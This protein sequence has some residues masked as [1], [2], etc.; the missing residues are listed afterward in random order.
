VRDHGRERPDQVAGRLGRV[1]GGVGI[2]TEDAKVATIRSEEPDRQPPT[3]S[4]RPEVLRPA[5]DL[6][7]RHGQIRDAGSTT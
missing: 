5:V 7:E 3:K 4:G 6:L 1:T 2:Q